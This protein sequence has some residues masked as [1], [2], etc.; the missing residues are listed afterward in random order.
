MSEQNQ[1]PQMQLIRSDEHFNQNHGWLNT[2][3]HFSFAEYHN[4]DK[5]NFGPMRVFNDDTVQPG[6]GFGFHPHQNMEIVSYVVDGMLEHKD[7]VG[8]HGI[9]SSGGIQQMTAGTG[10]VHS[11]FNSS[12][13]NDLHFLQMWF[14][15]KKNGLKPS[16]QDHQFTKEDR[17]NKFLQIV[18]SVDSQN[19]NVL[20]INQDSKLFISS[21]S[22]NTKL[23]YTLKNLRQA[24]VFIIDGHVNVNEMELKKR[25]AIMVLSE[26]NLS[27]NAKEET[28][29]ILVDLPKEFVSAN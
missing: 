19:P 25:D 24:Y 27:F 13:T 11:E 6:E 15:P 9:I 3:H 14:L 22:P 4:P 1:K 21:L 16:W 7:N 10:V 18:D 8:N 29:I 20:K 17:H 23:D 26:G 2:Y 28:E 12:K 5:M